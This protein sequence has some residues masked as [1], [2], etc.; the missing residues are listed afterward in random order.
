MV[1]TAAISDQLILVD[2]QDQPVGTC[3]KMEA[4]RQGLLH[5]AFSV[6]IFDAQGRMLLQQRAL[7]KYHSGGLWT[8]ACCSHPFPE[9]DNLAAA[10]RRL[11]EELGFTTSLRKVFDFYYKAEFDNGLTEHEFDHVFV[12]QYEGALE[13]NPQEVMDYCFL[14]LDEI[15]N[16]LTTRPD[17][18]T[19]W[20]KIAFPRLRRWKQEQELANAVN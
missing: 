7:S 1:S 9:E 20:F 14:S 8:N 15:E 2:E 6:F 19:E 5:R 16:Q 13:V 11:Q 10:S 3:E 4:H 18:Y 12:G 17:R